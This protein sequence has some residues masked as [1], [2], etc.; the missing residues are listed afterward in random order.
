MNVMEEIFRSQALST[1]TPT[2][3]LTYKVKAKEQT[4]NITTKKYWLYGCYT[5]LYWMWGHTM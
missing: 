4:K 2:C 5:G 1:I 3:L